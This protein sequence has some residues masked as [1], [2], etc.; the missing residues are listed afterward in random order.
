MGLP[1]LRSDGSRDAFMAAREGQ[2]WECAKN[3]NVVRFA[4]T[5]VAPATPIPAAVM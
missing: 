3:S 4:P 5:I 2:V 1:T